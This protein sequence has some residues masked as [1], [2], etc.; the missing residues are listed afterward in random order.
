[1]LIYRWESLKLEGVLLAAAENT[2]NTKEKHKSA[3]IDADA[4][5]VDDAAGDIIL[6]CFFKLNSKEQ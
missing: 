4:A 1:M 3:G 5:G 2:A 6:G